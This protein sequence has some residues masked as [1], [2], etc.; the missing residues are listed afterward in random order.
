MEKDKPIVFPDS[1]KIRARG[2]LWRPAR[3]A[4][5]GLMRQVLLE[6]RTLLPTHKASRL[7]QSTRRLSEGSHREGGAGDP[8]PRF[9]GMPQRIPWEFPKL[10]F[11]FFYLALAGSSNWAVFSFTHDRAG[12]EPLPDILF[13]FFERTLGMP[14]QEWAARW[15]DYSVTANIVCLVALLIFHRYRFLIVRRA[16]F[17]AGT[18]YSMRSVSLLVTQLP[19]GYTDN[20]A[21]CRGHENASWTTFWDRL[22]EQTIRMG[23]QAKAG[24][25]CGDLL[26]SGHTLVMMTCTLSVYHYLPKKWKLLAAVPSLISLFG[27]S[28]LIIS[29]THYTIDVIFAYW[30]T[31][32][33]FMVYHAYVEGD[34]FVER[35]QSVLHGMLIMKIVYWLEEKIIPGKVDNTLAIPFASLFGHRSP[36]H[37]KQISVSSAST[38][39]SGTPFCNA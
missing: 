27:M 16:F 6:E 32:F 15:G 13:D 24:M 26:F 25:L 38:F 23:F 5:S 35:K 20:Y 36:G 28:C 11:L 2:I 3:V 1:G 33:V 17:I 29:H 21:R 22:G 9:P 10:I 7:L 30:L 18:L 31:N 8:A 34:I 19:P 39:G 4:F 12:R 14:E 37:Q